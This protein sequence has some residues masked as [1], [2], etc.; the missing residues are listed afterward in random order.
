MSSIDGWR[1]V[2]RATL[3]HSRRHHDLFHQLF[4]CSFIFLPFEPIK[5]QLAFSFWLFMMIGARRCRDWLHWLKLQVAAGKSQLAMISWAP[6]KRPR[7]RVLQLSTCN[8]QPRNQNNGQ[9]TASE[10][11]KNQ[12]TSD[13]RPSRLRKARQFV[14]FGRYIII[15]LHLSSSASARVSRSHRIALRNRRAERKS[16]EQF[17]S[18]RAIVGCV[19]VCVQARY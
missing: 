6:I 17:N 15:V 4:P 9:A 18:R 12:T 5:M 10:Q 11:A 13:E 14:A 2:R 16:N 3:D 1:F 8:L 19:C 7:G